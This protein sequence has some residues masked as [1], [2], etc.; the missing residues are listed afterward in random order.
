MKRIFGMAS[1]ALLAAGPAM[2]S[3]GYLDVIGVQLKPDC[4]M[5]K[6]MSIVSDFRTWGTGHGYSVRIAVPVQSEDVQ[7][8]YW[9]GSTKDAAT[10]G[11]AWDAW[12]DA[13]GD[14]N[15][16]P[17]KLSARFGACSNNKSRSGYDVE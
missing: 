17:A 12:R 8:F 1:V 14:A 13:L 10:F 16:T 11:A 5:Q 4:T 9:E 6:Y 7:T 3:S 2:A 15:S